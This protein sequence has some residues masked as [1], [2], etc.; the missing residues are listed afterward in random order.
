M[1][2]QAALFLTT[3]C[4]ESKDSWT[5]SL[6]LLPP[7]PS[8]MIS[9]AGITL[10]DPSSDNSSFFAEED[11]RRL[12]LAEVLADLSVKPGIVYAIFPQMSERKYRLCCSLL[13]SRLL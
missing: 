6:H 3:L 12:W 2:R 7:G 1:R 8:K 10:T 5:R 9:K 4:L 11:E 13:V